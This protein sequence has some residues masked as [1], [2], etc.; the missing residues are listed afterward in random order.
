VE[1]DPGGIGKGYAVDR[2]AEALRRNGIRNGFISAGGSSIYALGTAP[3]KEGWPVKLDD[4]RRLSTPAATICLRDESLSTSGSTEKFFMADGKRW[5]HI[6][7]PRTG[8]PAGGMLSVSVIAPKTID[9]EAWAKP[10]F[11]LGRVWAE[12][13]KKREFQVFMCEDRANEPCAWIK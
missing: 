9:S 10:Y 12:Q 8:E 7:D 1:L 3:G 4:P 2:M 6:M 13:H 11:I 5:S